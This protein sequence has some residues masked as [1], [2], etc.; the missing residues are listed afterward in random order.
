MNQSK[1]LRLVQP[2]RDAV[3]AQ[4]PVRWAIGELAGSLVRHGVTLRSCQ[5]IAQTPG[6]GI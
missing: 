6:G 5:D 4:P 1:N 3:A 2:P